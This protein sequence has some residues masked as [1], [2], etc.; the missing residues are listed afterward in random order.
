MSYSKVVTKFID[1][2][3]TLSSAP[4]STDGGNSLEVP[5]IKCLI[6]ATETQELVLPAFWVLVNIFAHDMK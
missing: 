5:G 4:F 6:D 2:E 1:G 3:E